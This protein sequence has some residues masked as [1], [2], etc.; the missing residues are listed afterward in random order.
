MRHPDPLEVHDHA[1]G[2]R[3]SAH[4]S[5][6]AECRRAAETAESER[7]ALREALAGGSA[8]APPETLFVRLAARKLRRGRA[9]AASPLSLAGMAAGILSLLALGFLLFPGGAVRDPR[10]AATQP[11]PDPLDRL[12]A[13]FKGPSAERRALAAA[14]LPSFGAAAAERLRKEGLDPALAEAVPASGL[15][16]AA[17][18]D[19]LKSRRI[20]IDLQNASLPEV[21]EVF[22]RESGL[23]FV[24]DRKSIPEP[25][26]ERISFKVSDIV[27]DGALRLM[28]GPRWRSHVV[29]GGI[30]FVTGGDVPAVLGPAR[31]PVRVLR[32]APEAK[33][34]A[35]ALGSADPKEREGAESSLRLLGF[36]AEAALWDSLDSDD[37]EVRSRAGK[38]LRR[39]CTPQ[40]VARS[41]P[42]E[43]KLRG[44]TVAGPGARLGA[45]LEVLARETGASFVLD[46]GRVG[47]SLEVGSPSR[48]ALR[49]TLRR[50]KL[51]AVFFDDVILVAREGEP[52]LRREWNGPVWTAPDE[53]RRLESLVEGLSSTDAGRQEEAFRGLL[54]AGLS[55]IEPLDEAS[56]ALEPAAAARCRAARRRILDQEGAWMADEPSG[57]ELQPLA[58]EQRALLDRELSD[59]PAGLTLGKLLDHHG[60][61]HRM[62]V[63]L[64][65]PVHAFTRNLKA[66]SLLKVLTRPS[67][68]DFYLDGGTVVV[69]TA[70]R[71]RAAVPK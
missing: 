33:A 11:L 50:A 43:E 21:L 15:E 1:W 59:S 49:A 45:Y 52:I 23:R 26:A 7:D 39:L 13:E 44:A 12:I 5:S 47:P 2:F 32:D 36:G 41:F 56:R 42:V 37:P 64:D 19:L 3:P 30:V 57:A 54:S 18:V 46:P 48:D 38:L 4:V 34:L 62:A 29:R 22:E 68:L 55:A 60:I 16:D 65:V 24:I 14:A 51:Q 61:P 9:P 8:E 66:G 71:V 10:G 25:G 53:A 70:A 63:K 17:I 40:P 6:C 20:T 27:M 67:G 31:A 28:L 58:P 69:D 35:A